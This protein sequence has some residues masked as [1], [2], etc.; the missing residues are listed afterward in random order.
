MMTGAFTRQCILR[1]KALD[2]IGPFLVVLRKLTNGGSFA[3]CCYGDTETLPLSV[4]QVAHD[5]I[6]LV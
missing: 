2:R 4:P 5:P 3:F 1:P 6:F